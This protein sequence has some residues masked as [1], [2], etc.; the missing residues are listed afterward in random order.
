M[1]AD[2]QYVRRTFDKFNHLIFEGL[3]PEPPFKI[4]HAR[5]FLGLLRYRRTQMAD[6]TWRYGNFSFCISDCVDLPEDVA[7]DTVIHEMI[8]YYIL[9][10]QMQDTGPHGAIFKQKMH[11]I[12]RTYGRNITVQH[13]ITDAEA[14]SDKRRRL[15][16]ICVSRLA[17]GRVAITL[18]AHTA[19]SFN[20]LC[21][22][23]PHIGQVVYYEWVVSSDPYFNRIPRSQR[24]K[25]YVLPPDELRQHL[26]TACTLVRQ[27]GLIRPGAK[28]DL[29]HLFS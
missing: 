20:H 25:F 17:D 21:T 10:N 29:S 19:R 8:H 2:I 14:A 27:G 22:N 18:S 12:N 1:R 9:L 6:G 16:L 13:K 26:A 5:R 3:L 15:H 23:I 24:V 28:A 4:S 7:E 11:E